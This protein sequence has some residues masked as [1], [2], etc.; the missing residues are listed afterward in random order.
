[1][2]KATCQKALSF[3]FLVG[4][5]PGSFSVSSSSW[6]GFDLAALPSHL[7]GFGAIYIKMSKWCQINLQIVMAAAG[8]LSS[9]GNRRQQTK[10]CPVSRDLREVR[11][12]DSPQV[13]I[14]KC[15]P[16]PRPA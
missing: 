4:C 5:G 9:L 7:R 12:R 2:Q 8:M 3:S 11:V 14:T 15:A 13:C 6:S 10:F 16:I 1:M